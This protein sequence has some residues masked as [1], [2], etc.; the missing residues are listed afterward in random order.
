MARRLTWALVAS[1]LWASPGVLWA[2]QPEQ[3][4]ISAIWVY[5][6]AETEPVTIGEGYFAVRMLQAQVQ[7]RRDGW[8]QRLYTGP[9]AGT[10]AFVSLAFEYGRDSWQVPIAWGEVTAANPRLPQSMTHCTPWIPLHTDYGAPLQAK[11]SVAVRSVAKREG[12]VVNTLGMLAQKA[13]AA[14]I[15]SGLSEVAARMFSYQDIFQEAFTAAQ[16]EKEGTPLGAEFE[17]PQSISPEGTT[18]FRRYLLI[19]DP[20]SRLTR[21]QAD[22]ARPRGRRQTFE[23]Q[24]WDKHLKVPAYDSSSPYLCWADTGKLLEN[25]SFILLEVK[26]LPR[27][28]TNLDSLQ[29]SPELY[30]TISK[31][32]LT[33]LTKSL[34]AAVAS[35]A[36]ALEPMERHLSQLRDWLWDEHASISAKDIET[37]C[38]LVGRKARADL[39]RSMS[40]EIWESPIEEWTPPGSTFTIRVESLPPR[41]PMHE[42]R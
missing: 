2:R 22:A 19:V 38:M 11:M 24:D 34:R 25:A 18:R 36:D 37:I 40:R 29:R 39:E 7:V 16:P 32:I 9:V 31:L 42:G 1:V 27:F 35:E 13:T 17:I 41:T 8:F 20:V 33:P 30:R 3:P 15:P 12:G 6:S 23:W 14:S 28:F 10:E 26:T 5:S 4:P 21:I